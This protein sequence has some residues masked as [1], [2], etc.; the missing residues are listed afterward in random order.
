MRLTL[1]PQ[2]LPSLAAILGMLFDSLL[3]ATLERGGWIGNDLVNF[4][5]T[6]FAA[7]VTLAAICL[8][9]IHSHW[10]IT[11]IQLTI[12]NQQ[13]PSLPSSHRASSCNCRCSLSD[14]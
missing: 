14:V 1:P 5:S 4:L 10:R 8:A 9:Q 13:L 2:S 11:R 6:A 3:G 7:A 12:R